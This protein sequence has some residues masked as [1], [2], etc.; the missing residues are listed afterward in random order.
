MSTIFRSIEKKTGIT[1]Y[2]YYIYRKDEKQELQLSKENSSRIL[3]YNVNTLTIKQMIT[4]VSE[5]D[6]KDIY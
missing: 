5:Q 4:S 6:E 2:Y 3:Y 1:Y